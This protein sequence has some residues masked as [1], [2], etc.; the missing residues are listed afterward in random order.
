MTAH[1][2]PQGTPAPQVTALIARAGAS[3]VL[4]ER[5]HHVLGTDEMDRGIIGLTTEQV[6]LLSRYP[7][8]LLA[9]VPTVIRGVPG[10]AY[11]APWLLAASVFPVV[12]W[13]TFEGTLAK[14]GLLALTVDAA[15]SRPKSALVGGR[16]PDP[17]DDDVPEGLGD[18]E[19]DED[20]IGR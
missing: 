9:E 17:G 14:S 15:Q 4:P 6:V 2:F 18:G 19:V 12:D 8:E 10:I 5:L 20:G 1:I 13:A 3:L 7:A 16:I 11:P